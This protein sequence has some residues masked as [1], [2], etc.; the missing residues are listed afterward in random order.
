MQ[1]GYAVVASDGPGE[2][3]VAFSAHAGHQQPQ[4]ESGSVAYIT[5]GEPLMHLTLS[6]CSI[7]RL[8]VGSIACLPCQSLVLPEAS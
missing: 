2:Y 7:V 5:T 4:L 1:D 6:V 3:V 8:S